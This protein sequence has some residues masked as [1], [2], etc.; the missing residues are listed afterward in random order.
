MDTYD[1]MP[2]FYSACWRAIVK[3]PEIKM[4]PTRDG[5]NVAYQDGSYINIAIMPNKPRKADSMNHNSLNRLIKLYDA[6]LEK[7]I[8]QH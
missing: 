7:R 1:F 3:H 5:V 8:T 6:Y 4:S 2:L